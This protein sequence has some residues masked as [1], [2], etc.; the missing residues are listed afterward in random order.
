MSRTL[1]GGWLDVYLPLIEKFSESPR[2]WNWWSSIAAIQATMKRKCYVSRGSWRLYPNDYHVLVGRPGLGKGAAINPI[3]SIV[4]RANTAN[5]LSDKLTVEYILERLA[6]GFPSTGIG[7][8]GGVTFGVDTS[9]IFFAPELSVFLK[10]PDNELPELADLWDANEGKKQYGTRGKGLFEVENATPT[11]LGGCAPGWLVRSIPQHSISGGFTRRVNFVYY[12]G[13]GHVRKPW[14]TDDDT[15]YKRLTEPLVEDLRAIAQ[16]NGEYKF[17]NPARR[18]FEQI[19]EESSPNGDC[20]EAT[21]NYVCSRWAHITKASMAIAASHGDDKVI[22]KC[23]LEEAIDM[24]E[25]ITEGLKIVFRSVGESDM[26]VVADKVLLYLEKMPGATYQQILSQLWKDVTRDDLIVI[27]STLRDG[28]I[29][30]ERGMNGTL[31]YTA[32]PSAPKKT[33]PVNVIF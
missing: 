16:I 1:S 19:Y 31:I 28:G 4:R 30:N 12:D 26:V 20:D 2:K 9:C 25:D 22:C 24:V 13:E 32:P 21:S 17:D 15:T 5:I 14:P 33:R 23:H 3:L 18:L 11:M 27:L 29:I 8:N 7:V 10:Y 6:K